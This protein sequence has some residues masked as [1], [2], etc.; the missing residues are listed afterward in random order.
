M[1]G[2]RMKRSLFVMAVFTASVLLSSNAPALLENFDDGVADGW[3]PESGTTWIAEDGIYKNNAGE[4]YWQKSTVGW[5]FQ[6][7]N[8]SA[9]FSKGYYAAESGIGILFGGDY[10]SSMFAAGLW[11]DASGWIIGVN[12]YSWDGSRWQNV[13]G[14]NNQGIA[15]LSAGTQYTLSLDVSGSAATLTLGSDSVSKTLSGI[16]SGNIGLYNSV[17]WGEFDNFSADVV[18]EPSSIV[19]LGIGLAGIIGFAFKNRK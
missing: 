2:G 12:E 1:K 13:D 4:G 6:G 5:D 10:T 18:P 15:A 9:D 19:L 8:I 3:T 14:W 11:K 17:S 16:P 7:G